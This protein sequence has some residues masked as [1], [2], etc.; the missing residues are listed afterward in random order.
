MVLLVGITAGIAAAVYLLYQELQKQ[1][2]Q[3]REQNM[4]IRALIQQS[5][6]VEG[7]IYTY[8]LEH[9]HDS[10]DEHNRDMI[11]AWDHSMG[12]SVNNSTSRRDS[13]KQ[14]HLDC[15]H[16]EHNH[17]DRTQLNRDHFDRNPTNQMDNNDEND[18]SDETDTS[19][20]SEIH[21]SN[22][23]HPIRTQRPYLY[24]SSTFQIPNTISSIAP[25]H[26]ISPTHSIPPMHTTTSTSTNN[27]PPVNHSIISSTAS[28]TTPSTASSTASSTTS[29]NTPSI[30]TFDLD[31]SDTSTYEDKHLNK[32]QS[33]GN[34]S[35]ENQSIETCLDEKH[36][37]EIQS[38]G[39][40]SNDNIDNL[41]NMDGLK[42]T[43]ITTD[44]TTEITTI[45]LDTSES[46]TRFYKDTAFNRKLG[47]V[48][49]PIVSKNKTT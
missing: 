24:Q 1:R 8:N 7:L 15:N 44:I 10:E 3:I 22:F 47:R 48:G 14:P 12:Q 40:Q 29:S 18:E 9:L 41:K 35:I 32:N 49:Q 26:S 37:I 5:K 33:I 25:M 42:S 19:D 20:S 17:L 39:N 16:L 36:S 11:Y 23:K 31:E 6:R 46:D 4:Q 34:Q 21:P 13:L 28:S 30:K 27:T 43:D 2:S 38:I 45:D